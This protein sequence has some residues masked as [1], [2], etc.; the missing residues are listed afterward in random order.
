MKGKRRWLEW[1]K[2]LLIAALTLSAVYLLTMTPLVQDSGLLDLLKPQSSGVDGGGPV[3]LT[4]AAY[5]SR[6]AVSN[7]TGRYGLQYDQNGVDQLFAYLGPLLGE[8]LASSS[9]PQSIT[10]AAWQ[11]CLQGEGIFF[12]FSGSIPLSA[13]GSWLHSE[14]QSGL[15]A[16]ARRIL[17]A[18]GEDNAVLLCYQDAETEQFYACQTTLTCTLHL[19]PAVEHAESNGAL[20]AFESEELSGLLDPYTMIT[21]DMGGAVFAAANSLAGSE[22]V[23]ALLEALSFNGQNHASVSGGE[24]YLDGDS[25]LEVTNSGTVF[26]R[27]AQEG[28]YPVVSAGGRATVAEAIEAARELA[29]NTVGA[30]CGEARLYL[31]SVWET[32]DGYLVRFGYRLNGSAVWLYDEGWAAEFMIRDEYIVEFTLHFRSYVDTGEEALMLAAD[33]AAVMLPALA[34][35]PRELVVQYRDR[36]M[37]EVSPI[38]V[39]E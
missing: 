4:A 2:N 39:A 15:D 3:T 21:E 30:R 35:E 34:D 9:Q 19:H 10:E 14:G 20:F 5:P 24:A 18:A 32:D 26:Y 17:L 27:A 22:D 8:A 16:S 37:A 11:D 25:R 1:G 31:A 36:G 29:E 23:A 28:K 33:R 7:G 6:M 38:W 13:L 12:D